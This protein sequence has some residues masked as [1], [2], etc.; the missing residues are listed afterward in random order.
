MSPERA[1]PDRYCFEQT[2][3]RFKMSFPPAKE[4]LNIPEELVHKRHLLCVQVKI[5]AGD[6]VVF[7]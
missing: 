3:G 4:L 5:V 7:E 1:L 6:P 2:G